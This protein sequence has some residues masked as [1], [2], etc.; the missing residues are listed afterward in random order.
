LVS[1]QRACRGLQS[2]EVDYDDFQARIRSWSTL[3]RVSQYGSVREAG[4]RFPLLRL[5]VPGRRRVLITAGF[6]GE[7]PAGPLTLAHHF[8][9]IAAHARKRNIGLT[10]FPCINPSGFAAGTRYNASGEKPNNDLLR[11]RVG[12]NRWVGELEGDAPFLSWRPYRKSP[13]ETRALLK[14]LEPLATPVA[15]LDLHQDDYM[16]RAAT[17]AYVFGD[18]GHYR[19]LMRKAARHAE[20]A[21]DTLVD[22]RLRTDADGLIEFHDGSVTDYF[23][24]RGSKFCATL[25]TTTQTALESCHAVNLIWIFGFINLAFTIK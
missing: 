4:R 25:E 6:H 19:P 8:D 13:K 14:E 23:M 21:H 24:R 17:Y 7:E 20:V 22:P 16:R 18:P 2:P 3:A 10:V 1:Q 9:Q 5:D 12:K 11:Y 15:A